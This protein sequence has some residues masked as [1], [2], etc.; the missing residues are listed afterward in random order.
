MS[1]AI[2][3]FDENGLPAATVAFT[4]LQALA[5]LTADPAAALAALGITDPA[6]E[7]ALIKLAQL[8]GSKP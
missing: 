6:V 4:T 1:N 3:F 5:P 7:A 2:E 8:A